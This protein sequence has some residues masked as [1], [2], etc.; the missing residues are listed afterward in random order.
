MAGEV[1]LVFASHYMLA[2]CIGMRQ[3]P[4]SLS[5]A[6]APTSMRVKGVLLLVAFVGAAMAQSGV[7]LAACDPL[8]QEVRAQALVTSVPQQR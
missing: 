5:T 4:T 3:R 2:E 7:E 8:V 1:S 6:C